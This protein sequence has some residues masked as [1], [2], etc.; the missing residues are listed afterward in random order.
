MML[1]QPDWGALETGFLPERGS[2]SF[3]LRGDTPKVAGVFSLKLEWIAR[4]L[5]GR[6]VNGDV[7][8]SFE[9][10]SE[11][12]DSTAAIMKELGGSPYVTGS[13]LEPKHGNDV[14]YG[15]GDLIQRIARQ[16]ITQGNVILLEGNRRAGKTSILRHLEGKDAVP[17]WLA[18]Y[19]SLQGAEGATGTV[20]VPTA[21]IFRE[22]A[23]SIAAALVRLKIET[24]LPNGNVISAGGKAL[25]IGKACRDGI[26]DGAPFVDFREYLDVVMGL[27]NEQGL[28]LLLMLDEFD[29]IQEGI[30]HGVTSPQVP[31]NIRFMIE[32]CGFSAVWTGSRRLKR[33]RGV[34]VRALWPRHEHPGDRARCRRCQTSC[35]G[36]GARQTS[37]LT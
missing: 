9:V 22:I 32:A 11:A 4:G 31:E 17:G 35:R 2:V 33:L 24:P 3:T 23:G 21:S 13:P 14:F 26:S 12:S 7:Q 36:T 27:L 16:I 20:G 29:K 30:D 8:L 1:S 25:G 15:R 5:D 37:L 6:N 10:R 18:V 34:L 19:A 28:G